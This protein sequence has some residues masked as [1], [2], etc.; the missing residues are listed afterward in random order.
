[1]F[2]PIILVLVVVFVLL[3]LLVILMSTGSQK[4]YVAENVKIP[5]HTIQAIPVKTASIMSGVFHIE[6]DTIHKHYTKDVNVLSS[7]F[8]SRSGYGNVAMLNNT[9]RT[10]E[11][12]NNTQIF[13]GNISN[14]TPYS[15]QETVCNVNS[16]NGMHVIKAYQNTDEQVLIVYDKKKNQTSVLSYF[17]GEPQAPRTPSLKP[18]GQITTNVIKDENKNDSRDFVSTA[19]YDGLV[20]CKAQNDMGTF[21]NI[22]PTDVLPHLSMFNDLSIFKVPKHWE[23]CGGMHN[24]NFGGVDLHTNN[25]SYT[26]VGQPLAPSAPIART[27]KTIMDHCQHAW[28]WLFD[29][30]GGSL[31]A[32]ATSV[33][34]VTFAYRTPNIPTKPSYNL[35]RECLCADEDGETSES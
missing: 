13:K 10:I 24:D 35:T 2:S 28:C 15:I 17:R 8:R 23:N 34:E 14:T 4:A 5:P 30:N 1:M 33:G 3:L 25:A 6:E 19:P 11:I 20:H 9:D 26:L 21:D 31:P 29:E 12:P 32:N 18:H 27:R 22:R 16:R 7:H